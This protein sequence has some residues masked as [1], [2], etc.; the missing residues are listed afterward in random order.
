[1]RV[2]IVGSGVAG[3]AAAHA[4]VGGIRAH[5]GAAGAVTVFEASPRLGGHVYTVDADG[6]AI[7]MGFIVHNRERYPH[8]CALLDELG[9]ET[10]P[11][12]MSFSVVHGDLEWGSESL[13]AIFADR[14]RLAD[15]RHWRFLGSVIA[16]LR[17][18][19]ADL[20]TGLVAHASLDEY[21]DARR[22]SPEI[23][24]RFVVP[25][26]AALWSLA[27][28]LCG[29]FPA[30]TY[31]RFLDQHGMLRPLRPLAWRTIVGGSRRYV[32]ALAGRLRADGVVLRTG[33][34]VARIDRD[35]TGITV[36]A[37]RSE[38]RFDRII[39]AT[40]ADTALAL[41]AEPSEAERTTLGAFR[42][43]RNR[44]VLHCDRSFLPRSP[45]AHAAWNYVADPDTARVAVS[46]SMTRLQGLPDAP[47]LVTLNP[48][49]EPRGIFHEV[50]FDHPQLDRAALAAQ[51]SLP[52][53]GGIARTY[54][55]GAHFG[56]GF[57]EDGWRS[58]LAAAARLLSDARAA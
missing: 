21:L 57:H 52:R 36:L 14:R 55:A 56:F 22:I 32:D 54:Y 50:T 24:E 35:A 58:G 15:P 45:A 7:D 10:R 53:I 25:L 49:R 30:E 44:T 5:E 29:A 18:A 23:R 12:T 42:Y 37:D 26:A 48:R 41:L 1:M 31:F 2:A 16:F 43:S 40:H 47:Y 28:D 13:S 39:I 8:F 4:L 51:A 46:Y 6:L 17:R 27:P 19:R 9:I 33:S 3:L 38:H 20:G 11:A 34:S